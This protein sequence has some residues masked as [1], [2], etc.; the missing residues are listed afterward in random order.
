MMQK[1][2]DHEG[3]DDFAAM[4][5]RIEREQSRMRGP[6]VSNRIDGL[7]GDEA[8][9]VSECEAPKRITVQG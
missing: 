6:S 9:I 4:I 3:N 2:A 1:D 8:R 5:A 7:T